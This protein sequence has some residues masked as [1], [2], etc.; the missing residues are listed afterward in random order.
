MNRDLD[1][2]TDPVALFSEWFADAV[3]S[4]PADPDAMALATTDSAGMP[5]VRTVLLKSWDEAG[6]V[7]YTNIESAKGSQLAANPQAALCI[8]WKSLR[9]QVRIRGKVARVSEAEADGYY[10][11]RPRGSRIGAWVSRQSRPL[12]SRAKLEREVADFTAKYEVGE[13]P[14]PE[15]WSGYRVAPETME[16]WVERPF[17]LHDRI[18]FTWTGQGWTRLRLYP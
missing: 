5:D 18:R 12:E 14:R 4:E 1:L 16:F 7:F 15:H 11:S 13:I 6:F 3:A 10:A 9:R 2:T 17:R 8:Y